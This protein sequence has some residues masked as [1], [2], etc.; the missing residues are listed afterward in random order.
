M[1][2]GEENTEVAQASWAKESGF[3]SR[4]LVCTWLMSWDRTLGEER[5]AQ[6]SMELC[7]R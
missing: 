6:K 7:A 1:A 2:A 5:E 4:G 3:L